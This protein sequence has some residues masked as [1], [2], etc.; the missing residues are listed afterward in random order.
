MASPSNSEIIEDNPI[1][2]KLDAVRR[3]FDK[4]CTRQG[5]SSSLDA[6]QKLDSNGNVH[7]PAAELLLT[8]IGR[9]TL[10]IDLLHTL[11]TLSL[12]NQLHSET[13]SNRLA[14]DL[15][16][17]Y[18][19]V[20]SEGFDFKLAIPLLDAILKK[21]SDVVIWKAVFALVESR[22]T[23]A[24]RILANVDTPYTS[25]S[26]QG[27]NQTHDEVDPRILQDVNGSIF[28]GAEGFYQKYFEG[29]SWSPKVEE[30]VRGVKPKIKN[31]HWTEYPKPPNETNFLEW[32]EK[33]Q[34]KHFKET[35]GTF[36]TSRKPDL[37][38]RSS[39]ATKQDGQYQWTDVQVLGEL[40]SSENRKEYKKEIVRFCGYFREAF[41]S[42]PTRRFM[43]GFFI[44]GSMVELWVVDRSGPYS[45]KKLDIHKDPNR[46]VRV[47][48]G[49]AFMSDQELGRN[50]YI[51]EDVDGKY[52]MLR[53]ENK[54]RRTRLYLEDKPIASP[55]AI[56]CRGTTC[57]RARRKKSQHWEFVVKFSWRSDKMR[58]EGH[59]LRLAKERKVWGVAQ[60]FG[61]DDLATIAGLRADM[62][63]GKPKNFQLDKE[64]R[65][66]ANYST[67]SGISSGLV[68][69]QRHP[70]SSLTGSNRK[71][72]SDG[73]STQT[74]KMRAT[75]R[76]SRL[77]V[78]EHVEEQDD[79]SDK[80][81]RHSV[82]QLNAPS[83]TARA[84]QNDA[85]FDNRIF[86]CLV[87]SPPGRP[88]DQFK[89][90]KEFLEAC[91]DVVKALRSLYQ[92]G[93][94][95][96]RDV[97][98]NNI[99]ITDAES[100]GEPKVMLID[101]DL[102]KERDTPPSGAR[103]RTGTMKFMAIE[104]LKNTAHTY[105]HDLESFFYVFLWVIIRHGSKMGREETPSMLEDWYK[106][107]YYT[108][109]DMKRSH[110][111]RAWFRDLLDEFPT[112]F[113]GVKQLAEELR[114]ILFPIRDEALFTGTYRDSEKLYKPMIDAFDKTIPRYT[115]RRD[116]MR[117]TS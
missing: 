56:V 96:H 69:S 73:S 53:G 72:P 111:D 116:K 42:Q 15:S 25:S 78:A 60:L 12:S 89:S 39:Q 77:S 101:L 117:K 50:A 21:A 33:F 46:F 20:T 83:L 51:E 13:S 29:K 28:M 18:S 81:N 4:I 108:I 102:A 107:T 7:Q 76:R 112:E 41:K 31:G 105:R 52:I 9:Q 16:G 30:I 1:G 100:E 103:Y 114:G 68:P 86:S 40:K 35:R 75:N 10:M 3:S 23:P 87:I 64:S 26:H 44:R 91:R 32:F 58:A 110:M 57:Y 99:I 106:G 79:T 5:L 49:Y 59:L 45:C 66:S 2:E 19:A 84:N 11:Q 34:K 82:E 55:R 104:V 47:M 22:A 24:T 14:H 115:K 74:R 80:A 48:A 93:G 98:V 43:H 67:I 6:A 94:I 90:I 65:F 62:E 85:T 88:I 97:S 27:S 37:F 63:F 8:H 113:D 92:D 109:A 95:I 17:L 70:P 38:L 36:E 54:T 71:R 61:H